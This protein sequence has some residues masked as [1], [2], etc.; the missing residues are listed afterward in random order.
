MC[1]HSFGNH[2]ASSWCFP[3]VWL[4]G[5]VLDL[6]FVDSFWM[7]TWYCLCCLG[8]YQVIISSREEKKGEYVMKPTTKSLYFP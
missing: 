7:A 3:Q 5:G 2:L 6:C 1:R 8:S 4:Q